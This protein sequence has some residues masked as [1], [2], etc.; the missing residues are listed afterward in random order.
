MITIDYI[1]DLLRR[2]RAAPAD[3]LVYERHHAGVSDIDP[4][5]HRLAIHGLVR[6][7]KLFAMDVQ[8][9]AAASASRSRGTCV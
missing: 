2:A 6:E 8:V 1:E 4:G 7:P 3:G 9:A 5:A